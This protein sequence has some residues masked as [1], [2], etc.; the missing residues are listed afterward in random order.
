LFVVVVVVVVAGGW[1]FNKNEA[2]LVE[3]KDAI[4]PF[5]SEPMIPTEE[6]LMLGSPRSPKKENG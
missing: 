2:N 1:I 5:S 3:K 6:E 4:L